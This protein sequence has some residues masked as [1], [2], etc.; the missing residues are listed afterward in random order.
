MFTGPHI[1]TEGL[2]LHLDAANTKSYLGSGTTWFDKSGRG[3]NGALTNG[4]TFNSGN[5]GSIV[6]DGVNDS[7]IVSSFNQLP[8]GSN[9]RT[10]NIWFNTNTT[11]WQ[12]NVNNLFFYGTGNNGNAFGID[13]DV[14]P[15]MEI[16][17]WGGP[18]R[19]FVFSTT[20]PQVG[21]S[22]LSIVYNGSTSLSIYEN[23]KNT[24]NTT[25][26]ACNTTNTSVWIGSINPTIQSWY[27]DGKI[28]NMQIYNRA[29]TPSEVEQNYNAT[30]TRFGL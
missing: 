5:G 29:L 28:S 2:V 8:T 16:Y 24:Q 20:F 22:N 13:F 4:P 17:T 23:S 19:D 9:A 30:K 15:T 27:F 18:G 7:V 6:F 25:I 26:I 3:N 10:I 1:V 11:T 12:S 21:W 14:Y